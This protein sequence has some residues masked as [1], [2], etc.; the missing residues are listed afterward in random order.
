MHDVLTAVEAR[1]L[2][3]PTSAHLACFSLVFWEASA[4]GTESGVLG[5]ATA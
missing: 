2:D 5:E 3:T 4:G 1:M